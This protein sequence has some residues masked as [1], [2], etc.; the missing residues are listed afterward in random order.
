MK[1]QRVAIES[2]GFTLP[3][4]IVTSLEIEQQ[5]A[6]TYERLKLPEGRLEL[7]SGIAQR[8]FW[9][10][11]TAISSS[12]VCSAQ[13]ALREADVPAER[14]G[15]LIHASVCRDYLEPATACR[16]HAQLGL[17]SDCWVYDL[18]NAC[19]GLLSGMVQVATLIEQGC[20]QAGI[21]VGTESA[22]NLVESTIASLN[23]DPTLTRQSIKPS[24]ASLTIGSGSCAILLVDRDLSQTGNLLTSCTVRAET[25]HH[26]LCQSDGDQAGGAMQPLMH[27]DS[28]R[29]LQAGVGVG[30][31]TFQQL[32][33]LG[34]AR[35][36]IDYT[37]S[38]QVGAAH[39]RLMLQQLG[40]SGE[41]DYSTFSWLGNTG[42]VAL[43]TALAMGLRSGF[44]TPDSRVALLG[45]G[46]GINSLMMMTHWRQPLV[47]G[48]LDANA[49]QHLADSVHANRELT[50]ES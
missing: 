9:E 39:R 46:S 12:S 20:I 5:L 19:L 3:S 6:P 21:V 48:E 44:I 25:R 31:R 36:Q 42:S 32:L 2:I 7:M 29:L 26:G 50:L 4:Q 16:V 38:H 49:Q 27:T 35:E 23:A 24:F 33:D 22:R 28:E 34:V 37:V 11:G 43:P 17:P 14:I 40:L 1:F 18:S 30:Q 41:S 47:A 13:L 8:R 10:P 45:I 15:C